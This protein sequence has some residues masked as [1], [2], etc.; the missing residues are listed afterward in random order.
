M[1]SMDDSQ[2]RDFIEKLKTEERLP[3]EQKLLDAI[4]KVAS[5]IQEEPQQAFVEEYIES[6][7]KRQADLVLEYLAVQPD[8]AH[9][10][11]RDP[12]THPATIIRTPPGP[13]PATDD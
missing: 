8:P 9:T 5:D 12:P 4:I 1:T 6:F 2:V 7:T 13:H 10:I 11:L 3:E